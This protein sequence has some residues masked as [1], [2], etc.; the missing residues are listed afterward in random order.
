MAIEKFNSKLYHGRLIEVKQ[1]K[2][3]PLKEVE[4]NNSATI[5]IRGLPIQL[6]ENI[7]GELQ[8]L[9]E[10]VLIFTFLNYTIYLV[11]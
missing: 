5:F 9:F 7:E 2:P 11:W 1:S 6:R 10:S 8:S 3:P 4:E